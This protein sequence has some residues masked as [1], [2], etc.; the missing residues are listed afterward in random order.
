[1]LVFILFLLVAIAHFSSQSGNIFK[2][3]GADRKMFIFIL[4]V[5][6]AIAH[7]A[8]QTINMKKIQG[9]DGNTYM[10]RDVD[11]K[12]QAV[13]TLVTL[14]QK[15]ISLIDYVYNKLS[16]S[17]DPTSIKYLPYVRKI[18]EKLPYVTIKETPAHTSYTSFSV[19]KG[20]EL[21]FCIR[22]KKNNSMHHINDLLYVAIHEIAH[23]GCPEIGHTKLFYD[24]NI[25]LLKQ[26]VE[27][28][29][30]Q[31]TNYDSR[32]IEYCGIDLNHSV[33]NKQQS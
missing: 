20:Q 25:F 16:K 9:A 31:Y 19:N 4:F 28:N 23:I 22:S 1:M 30:Y 12:L 33:L 7:N 24:I 13:Q 21:N 26:A 14:R 8:Y 3:Q 29:M 10:V 27:F 2:I 32:P 11:D 5:L 17:S 18:K 6:V 15:L